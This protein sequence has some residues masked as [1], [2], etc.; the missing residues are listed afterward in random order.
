MENSLNNKPSSKIKRRGKGLSLAV[1][2]SIFGGIL[3]VGAVVGT[4]I[5][6][7]SP[8]R[9]TGDVVTFASKPPTTTPA[10][11][12]PSGLESTSITDVTTGAKLNLCVCP[13][14]EYP[15]IG[16]AASPLTNRVTTPIS[17]VTCEPFKCGLTDEEIAKITSDYATLLSAQGVSESAVANLKTNFASAYDKWEAANPACQPVKPCDK[18]QLFINQC[19]AICDLPEKYYNTPSVLQSAIDSERTDDSIREELKKILESSTSG[20]SYATW[21]ANTCEVTTI[22]KKPVETC[23]DVM[24]ALLEAYNKGDQTAFSAALKKLIENKCITTCDQNFFMAIYSMKNP[25]FLTRESASLS[26]ATA[27]SSTAENYILKYLE[28][29]CSDCNKTYGLITAY[30]LELSSQEKPDLTLL[31]KLLN[32]FLKY[33]QCVELETLLRS[34]SFNAADYFNVTAVAGSTEIKS[35]TLNT[36]RSTSDASS[37]STSSF[38]SAAKTEASTVNTLTPTEKAE[39]STITN[40]STGATQS[41]AAATFSDFTTGAIESKDAT[42]TTKNINTNI[43]NSTDSNTFDLRYI[44]SLLFEEAFAQSTALSSEVKALIERMYNESECGPPPVKE[45]PVCKNLDIFSPTT[46]SL[47]TIT[48]DFDPD[49][50]TLAIKVDGEEAVFEYEYKTSDSKLEFVDIQGEDTKKGLKGG[51]D[52]GESLTITVNAIGADGGIIDQCTDTLKVSKIKEK[53]RVPEDKKEPTPKVCKSLKITKPVDAQD[54]EVTL[55]ADGYTDETLLIEVEDEGEVVDYKFTSVSDNEK[56]TFNG[57]KTLDTTNT[58]I[59]LNADLDEGDEYIITV[60][61]RGEDEDGNLVGLGDCHDSFTI[62]R[63]KAPT[64]TPTTP[65]D[66]TTTTISQTE[67]EPETEEVEIPEVVV[68]QPTSAPEQPSEPAQAEEL[69]AAAPAPTAPI[70]PKSG[71]AALIYLVGAGIGGAIISRRK[72][73]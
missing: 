51:P 72:K 14:N 47:L 3:I 43:T 60:W 73:K 70:V 56:I 5:Y 2:L 21:H 7:R 69:H 58:A 66:K 65:P 54:G 25:A 4:L 32:V 8:E 20:V 28:G 48:D 61:A 16:E 36:L 52:A 23:N 29:S 62:K 9:L 19:Y 55:D 31:E 46:D 44:N 38:N 50:D 53:E 59:K 10:I 49:Q 17:Q 34:P 15:V 64:D 24:K 11:T 33:C 57:E 45:T 12:C 6:S 68:I 67:P 1:I 13:A 18:G 22:E 39:D 27:N 63:A 71:P 41:S 37:L 42:T 26:F 40:F 35:E 30:A